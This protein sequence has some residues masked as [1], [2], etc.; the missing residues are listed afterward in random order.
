MASF[1]LNQKEVQAVTPDSANNLAVTIGT[2]SFSEDWD[3]D[4]ATTVDNFI[5]SFGNELNRLGILAYDSGDVLGLY[6]VGQ[7]FSTSNTVSGVNEAL[8]PPA[9]LIT[10]SAADTA[11]LLSLTV[12]TGGTNTATYVGTYHDNASRDEDHVR[13]L[14]LVGL[15]RD[16]IVFPSSASRWTA[17]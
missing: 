15:E 3:T 8:T 2:K 6:G 11:N 10:A 13:I 16:S 17:S 12:A 1:I 5:T 4:A 14:N 7:E 9:N